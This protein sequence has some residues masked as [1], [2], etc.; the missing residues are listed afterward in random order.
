MGIFVEPP[1]VCYVVERAGVR[2]GDLRIGKIMATFVFK[3]GRWTLIGALGIASATA[4]GGRGSLRNSGGGDGEAGDDGTGFGGSASSFGGSTGVAGKVTGGSTGIGGSGFG[5]STSAGG[6]IGVGG[7]AGFGGGKGCGFGPPCFAPYQCVSGTCTLNQTCKP[8]QQTCDPTEQWLLRCLPDGSGYQLVQ[9]CQANGQ[10]CRDGACRDLLCLP[11]SVSCHGNDLRICSADGNSSVLLQSCRDGLYC[12]SLSLSCQPLCNPNTSDCNGDP[13]DGC[14]T[15][16]VVDPD[17]CGG[18]GISCSSSHL[19]TRACNGACSGVCQTGYDDCNGDKQGDG[20]ETRIDN[21]VN[22]CGAC[23]VQC[24][25]NHVTARCSDGNCDGACSVNFADCNGDKQLDGCE[26][27]A[28]TDVNN[29]G[30][31][32]VRCSSNHITRACN[33]GTCEGT[34]KAGWA[35]CN[36]DKQTDGCETSVMN[37]P[38]NCGG[39][40]NQCAEGGCSN[41]VCSS[42]FTFSGIKQNLPTASLAGWTECHADFYGEESPLVEILRDCA[43]SQLLLACRKVGSDVLQLAA[44]AP[45]EEVTFNTGNGDVLHVANGVGWYFSEGESWGFAPAGGTVRRFTCDIEDSALQLEG[46]DGDKRLCWHTGAGV[47]SSGW[48]CGEADSLNEDFNYERVI[49]AAP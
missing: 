16:I 21:N 46:K 37:D 13:S 33:Q 34:C 15:N 8:L 5:G 38:L 41:G 43:G 22:S 47:L 42:L 30:A 3:L 28:R 27:D 2:V 35:D 19:A 32:G 20:C 1:E 26:S 7:L 10:L 39:C 25:S 31:C 49:F 23:G 6:S 45:F 29:C 17:N 12:D 11:G 14:E 24:S 9:S 4:C 18:C 36:D 40:N 48:R 44:H